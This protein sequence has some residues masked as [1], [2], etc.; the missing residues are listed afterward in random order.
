MT[1]SEIISNGKVTLRPK[2]MSDAE[3][4]YR[5]RKDPTLNALDGSRPLNI[6][7]D[8]F[9]LLYQQELESPNPDV[10]GFS[11]ETLYKQH[12]GSC[13][14]YNIDV[15]QREAEVGIVIGEPPF[16]GQHYGRDA[17]LVLLSFAFGTLWLNRAYLHTRINNVR[18]KRC[19]TGLG[20]KYVKEIWLR[21]YRFVQM[22]IYRDELK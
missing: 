1:H 6:S 8:E 19:F 9:K 2:Q 17:L 16:W 4:D 7:F 20:F 18:A 15:V 21:D 10:R 14:C 13:S 5:W 3:N 11:I 12:I 22:E